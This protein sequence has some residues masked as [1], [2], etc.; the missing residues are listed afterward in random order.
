MATCAGMMADVPL[1]GMAA[2]ER[3]LEEFDELLER[4]AEFGSATWHASRRLFDVHRIANMLLASEEAGAPRGTCP[5]CMCC[6]SL[7][8]PA[9]LHGL[10]LLPRVR[11]LPEHIADAYP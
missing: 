1:Y 11:Q 6:A 4:E 8:M 2:A 5:C 3:C 10:C 9:Q 7:L